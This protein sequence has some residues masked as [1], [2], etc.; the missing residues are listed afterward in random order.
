MNI[1]VVRII[2]DLEVEFSTKKG[3][4]IGTWYNE[5]EE[6]KEYGV[7]FDV[8][9]MVKIGDNAQ[10]TADK[11]YFIRHDNNVNEIQGV[12]DAVDDDGLF[13]FR[14]SEDCLIMIEQEGE[15]IKKGDWLLLTISPE[16]L[17]VMTYGV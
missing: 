11:T 14:L 13:Y 12:V 8:Y 3:N 10:R 2:K 5:V 4:G 6:G 15:Q 17:Q 7:E 9:P 16:N 1:K